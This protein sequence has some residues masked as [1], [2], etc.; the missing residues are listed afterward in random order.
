MQREEKKQQ[1]P[2]GLAGGNQRASWLGR[3]SNEKLGVRACGLILAS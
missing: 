2:L 1:R 3:L